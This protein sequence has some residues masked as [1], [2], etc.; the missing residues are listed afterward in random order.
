MKM[1]K[2]LKITLL[3]VL[4]YFVGHSYSLSEIQAQGKGI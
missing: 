1:K 2:Y 3:V 4:P